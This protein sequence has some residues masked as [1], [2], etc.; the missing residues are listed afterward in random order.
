MA[1]P[2]EGSGEKKRKN[3]IMIIIIIHWGKKIIVHKRAEFL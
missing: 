3:Q 2:R 1:L